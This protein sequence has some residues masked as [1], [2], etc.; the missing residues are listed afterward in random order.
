[1]RVSPFWKLNNAFTKVG[2]VGSNV[3]VAGTAIFGAD[4][5]EKVIATLKARVDAAQARIRA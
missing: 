3:I 2:D 4:D 1:M 5:P